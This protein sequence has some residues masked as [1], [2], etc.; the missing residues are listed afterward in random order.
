MTNN[1][2]VACDGDSGAD[3]MDP[4]RL[5]RIRAVALSWEAACRSADNS[6]II[7][8]LSENARVWYNFDKTKWNS[9]VEYKAI[10]DESA[11]TFW[12]RKY[13][14]IRIRVHAQ[15]F[16]E[17][18]TITGITQ[19]GIRTKSFLLIAKVEGSKIISIEEY[20]DTTDV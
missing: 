17:Q 5:E 6:R 4:G 8:H 13:K 15:G 9:R 14:N 18:A 12:N 3:G 10:L 1:S 16:V 2:G 20:F 7:A 19:N 11:K